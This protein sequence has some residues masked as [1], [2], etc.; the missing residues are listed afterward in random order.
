[1]MLQ[2]MFEALTGA[3]AR[4]DL[5]HEIPET[6][7]GKLFQTFAWGLELIRDHTERVRLWENI[8][9]A[10]GVV[11][12]RYGKTLGVMRGDAEDDFYR[13]LIKVKMIAQLSGGDI[14]T[15]IR[16]AA[17]LFDLAPEQVEFTELF[18]AKVWLYVND[19]ELDEA[20]RE[21][22]PLIAGVVKRILAA[23]V[24]HKVF[25]R[26]Y[27]GSQG[28]LYIGAAACGTAH[29]MV[30]PSVTAR[31]AARARLYTG[32]AALLLSRRSIPVK[33]EIANV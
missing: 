1:M 5:N 27:Y 23:G 17:S 18:P 33:G 25:L 8:D 13:L 22:A 9:N 6:A 32:G 4:T 3:Y 14:D 31:K 29:L 10:A 20:H 12:D 7:I 26:N 16:A 24:G 28:R 2:K 21:L 15:V 30:P 19:L 11:L